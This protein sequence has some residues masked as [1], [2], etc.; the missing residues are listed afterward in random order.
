[1][2][3]LRR[4][5]QRIKTKPRHTK[6]KV[7]FRNKKSVVRRQKKSS[8][9]H[10]NIQQQHV[11]IPQPHV[12]TQQH[13]DIDA[14]TEYHIVANTAEDI[15]N[16]YLTPLK[17]KEEKIKMIENEIK[18]PIKK[19]NCS[20]TQ[21]QNDFTCYGENELH[22][23][24]NMW[25]ERNPK[26]KI[27]E[28]DKKKIWIALMKKMKNVCDNEMCWLKQQFM[29]SNISTKI[30]KE[31]FAP[32]S[33]KKWKEN[34]NEWLSN[35]DLKDV[36]KQYENKYKDFSFIGPSPIDFDKT[37]NN[38]C[39][40]SDLCAFDLKNYIKRGKTKIG[41]IFNTDPHDQDG[42]H[43]I[44]LFINVPERYVYFFNSTGDRIPHEINVL[45]QRIIQQSKEM[46]KELKFSQNAPKQHQRGGTEC[47]MYSLYFIINVLKG[48]VKPAFFNT[49]TIPDKEVQLFRSIFFNPSL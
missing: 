15:K 26:H 47:G 19:M 8:P 25:N 11:N 16:E 21:E 36:M 45:V 33:P 10:V 38:R 48:S 5:R 27:N 39:I 35:F 1:M 4:R 40:W 29:D 41:I 13:K 20:P 46:G 23:I 30:M 12:N 28:T 18:S 6:K 3:T 2:N 24:K 9:H 31:N 49:N 42:S 22:K 14:Y 37:E 17:I 7:S 44:S 32:Q 43:W 34:P